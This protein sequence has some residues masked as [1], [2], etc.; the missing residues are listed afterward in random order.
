MVL[1]FLVYQNFSNKDNLGGIKITK[2]KNQYNTQE[3]I[4]LSGTA[5]SDCDITLLFNGQ[6]GILKSDANGR[7]IANLG[8]APA[9]DYDIEAISDDSPSGRSIYVGQ[10]SVISDK[11]V[12]S[13]IDNL[14]TS[15][16]AGISVQDTV[17]NKLVMIS[18]DAPQVLNG[19]W[20]LIK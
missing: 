20:K 15:M 11:K 7:W 9:G 19:S 16:T 2:V 13:Y 17:P 1:L 8:K 10:I 5:K 14:A 6:M 4:V 3:D 12:F 18:D